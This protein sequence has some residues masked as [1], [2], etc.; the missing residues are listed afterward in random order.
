[1]KNRKIVWLLAVLAVLIIFSGCKDKADS[2]D[3]NLM[4]PDAMPPSS[5]QKFAGTPVAN[6]TEARN[7]YKD[8][9]DTHFFDILLGADKE[10]YTDT[11]KKTYSKNNFNDFMESSINKDPSITELSYSV[12]IY[13][14]TRYKTKSGANAAKITGS[15]FCS[16]DSNM[17]LKE[18][19][20]SISTDKP[21]D[22]PKKKGDN[23]AVTLSGNRTCE[24]SN[25]F[26]EDGGIKIAGFVIV[27]YDS[28][29]A[30]SLVDK[31]MCSLDQ[32]VI[33]KASMTLSVSDGTKGAKFLVSGAFL[34]D[35]DRDMQR[36]VSYNVIA[37]NLDVYDNDDVLLFSVPNLGSFNPIQ[38]AIIVMCNN[39][40]KTGELELSGIGF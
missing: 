14:T 33:L 3:Y 21:I 25:G 34:Y 9:Q 10:A 15:E 27:E 31:D 20:T 30:V 8:M 22:V 11:F 7:L 2:D 26:Y 24:I 13:D 36:S 23:F 39:N 38:A 17:T 4:L 6:Y 1:M 19:V 32:N 35:V 29:I 5:V 16:F 28:S 18:F 40:E 37:S 12:D